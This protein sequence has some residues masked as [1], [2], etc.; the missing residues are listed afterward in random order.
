MNKRPYENPIVEVRTVRV[1]RELLTL[2]DN[3]DVNA[4]RDAYG[5]A[6]EEDW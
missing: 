5:E 6:I 2:S 4:T 3:S 1:E